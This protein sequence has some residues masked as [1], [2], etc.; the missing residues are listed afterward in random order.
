MGKGK[1][2]KMAV[3]KKQPEKKRQKK[4]SSLW[5]IALIAVILL[6]LVG[7][8]FLVLP[9]F[10]KE[11]APEKPETIKVEAAEKSY[12]AGSRISEKNFRV[13]GISGKKKQLLDADTYSVSPAKVPAH[14]HSVT[15]EVSSK[16][17][18]DIKAEITVL[19]DRDESARYKIGRENPD[20]VEAILYSNGD[21][22]IAGKG[23]VRNF[24]SDS[25]P[26]KKYSV[27]RLTWIDPEAEVE[28]M[29]YWFTGNDE[30][31]ETL[32]R[33]PDTVRSMV[34]TFK[35]ATAMTSMP[36]M[37]G[38]VR[39]EDI[40][41][42]AEGCIALEK[43]MELPGN[44]KQAKKAFYGDTALIEGAD[45]TA[46]MQLENMDSMYYGC[47]ALASVQIPDS[48][49]ELSNICNGCV[50]LKEVHIPSAAQKMN[51]SFFGC[52]ALESITGEIP[53]S[54]TDSGNLFS[55]CKFLSG[56]L[57]VSCTSR[58]TLSSSFSDAATTGTGL[59]IILRY[60]AEKSQETANTGFYGGTK[61]ADEI[62]NALKAS[63]EAAFSSG[64][65]ITITTNADKT[66]G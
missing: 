21:L 53:S 24:K 4:K 11:A 31:L 66:E 41:S 13:Y 58:T 42:C 39:L 15:V 65:H 8:V 34:E 14:G 18:P 7:V 37:S 23:S 63:M 28:S 45:T 12:A 57:T 20:D 29:D 10:R 55:G 52:T 36:D 6:I 26:W 51:S 17:Y 40:T 54:C 25:A 60:D 22:E 30:Y 62:L 27:K 2:V 56:T 38:A 32:C 61:S 5:I 1:R 50:N 64:S 33:I 16:A 35:N 48:A 3:S 47:M 43:A 19:I 49:K 46:C 44:I 9:K 59:T